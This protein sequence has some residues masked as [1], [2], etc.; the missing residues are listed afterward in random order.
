M[1]H[2]KI[3]ATC[4]YILYMLNWREFCLINL[5]MVGIM[6]ISSIGDCPVKK[7]G[8]RPEMKTIKT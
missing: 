2:R 5:I 3:H 1:V 4:I 6:Y 8:S 7:D